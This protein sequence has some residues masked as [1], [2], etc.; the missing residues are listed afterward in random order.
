MTAISHGDFVLRE[1]LGWEHSS[2]WLCTLPKIKHLIWLKFGQLPPQDCIPLMHCWTTPSMVAMFRFLP[3]S[4]VLTSCTWNR[5]KTNLIWSQIV[6]MLYKYVLFT[7]FSLIVQ[8]Y[9]K[10]GCIRC[11]FR[12]PQTP[13]KLCN[14]SILSI[15]V[16]LYVPQLTAGL[17]GT[18]TKQSGTREKRKGTKGE[19][20]KWKTPPKS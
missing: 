2:L 16:T 11:F 1:S 18:D 9:D 10:N 20:E 19:K 8:L 15:Y 5:S 3:G 4:P 7:S 17:C 13:Y 6:Y 12:E 14:L